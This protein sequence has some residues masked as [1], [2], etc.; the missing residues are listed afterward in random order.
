MANKKNHPTLYSPILDQVAHDLA[1]QGKTNEEIADQ[2][3]IS[4]QTFYEWRVRHPSFK[5]AHQ[6]GKDAYDSDMVEKAMLE[7]AVG[8]E[9]EEV[10]VEKDEEG[11]WVETKKTKKWARNHQAQRMWLLNRNRD[12]W[13]DQTDVI[14]HDGDL[15]LKLQLAEKRLQ[16]LRDGNAGEGRD[17]GCNPLEEEGRSPAGQPALPGTGA[18]Q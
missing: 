2:F 4:P 9:S 18:D 8:H 10:V 13:K 16:E 6:S 3:G 15:E 1:L 11:Q 12:R 17:K 5:E 7:D 14:V